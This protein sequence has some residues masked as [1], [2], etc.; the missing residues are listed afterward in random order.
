M[1]VLLLSSSFE[2][3]NFINLRRAIRLYLNDK[4]DAVSF[5]DSKIRT[6]EG[7]LDF[8]SVLR[9][10]KYYK[11]PYARGKFNRK[12][13]F[14][15]DLYLCQ[16]C[17]E[18]VTSSSATLD[19]VIPSAKGGPNSWFNCV[20]ACRP[21]NSKKRDRTPEEAN[22]KLISTPTIPDRIVSI[23]YALE[24]PKHPDWSDYFRI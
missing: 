8:P 4:V 13:V 24:K 9:L 10:K 14:G 17:E 5:W 6:A 1:K 16:Y 12:A 3:L 7:E 21:C 23:D 15:R 22:M 20:T 19:H 18:Q 2:P 11:I